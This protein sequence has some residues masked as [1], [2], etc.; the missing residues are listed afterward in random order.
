MLLHISRKF[1]EAIY[2]F[3]KVLKYE[4]R[5]V[6]AKLALEQITPAG[7]KFQVPELEDGVNGLVHKI[8][9]RL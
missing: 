1:K 4:P 6:E 8:V 7:L 5:H 9:R 3:Q 2:W